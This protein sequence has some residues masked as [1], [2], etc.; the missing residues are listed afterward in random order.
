M[1]AHLR[2]SSG[3]GVTRRGRNARPDPTLFARLTEGRA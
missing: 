1:L 3:L 2:E